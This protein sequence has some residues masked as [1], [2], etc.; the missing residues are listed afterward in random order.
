MEYIQAIEKL[1]KDIYGFYKLSPKRR[2]ALVE[3]AKVSVTQAHMNHTLNDLMD[4][5]DKNIAKGIMRINIILI[6]Q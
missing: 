4:V 1:L 2:N 3:G 5:M 6:V